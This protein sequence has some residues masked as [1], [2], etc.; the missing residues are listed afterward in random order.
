MGNGT[1]NSGSIVCFK[2]PHIYCV[3]VQPVKPDRMSNYSYLE[4][5]LMIL[6]GVSFDT[7]GRERV[8][9]GIYAFVSC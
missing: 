6:W 1:T 9:K 4:S 2:L 5:I 3:S 8:L 7:L